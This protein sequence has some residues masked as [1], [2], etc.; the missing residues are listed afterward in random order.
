[1]L[2]IKIFNT[3][4]LAF[5]AILISIQGCVS[6]DP[7]RTSFDEVCSYDNINTCPYSVYTTIGENPSYKL[8]FI[9]FDDQGFL[10][11]RDAKNSVIEE[12]SKE[13]ENGK[14]LIITFIHGWNHNAKGEK[15]ED[16]DITKFRELLS[17]A[18]TNYP[19]HKVV[20]LYIGWRGRALKGFLNYATFWNRKSTAHEIGV[21]GITN[22][23]LELEQA[24]KGEELQYN[25]NTMITI[26]HSFGGAAL[27]SAVQPI[28]A[29]RY[30]SSRPFG[31]ENEVQGFGDL[32]VL[33]NP[34]FEAIRY[35]SLYELSQD[36]C[37]KYPSTQNPRLV[38]LS[39]LEDKAVRWTFPVG[40][41]L[42]AVTENHN[43]SSAKYCTKQG[44]STSS[45]SVVQWKA[46]TKAVGH[47]EAY[48]THLLRDPTK[49]HDFKRLNSREAKSAILMIDEARS[50]ETDVYFD[51]T[52]L[53]SKNR[54]MPYNP[55]LNIFT[56]D[57]IMTGHN[58][59]W[60]AQT[61]IFIEALI[62][63]TARSK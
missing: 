40:R 53:V 43:I 37:R 32:I 48:V 38:I 24:V 2:L 22:V 4:V 41:M 49:Y 63:F 21:N 52:V 16:S 27:F 1:M 36:R 7:Y 19:D 15:R 33:M 62:G 5:L 25:H 14:V 29:E 46:D 56:Q 10:H 20:G 12:I 8:G 13:S 35:Q 30:I 17:T 18:A 61:T 51:K 11:S 59:I 50:G 39:A 42:N 60:G 55:Y 28:L 3:R 23:L 34:A 45:Y 26:G 6:N 44:D 54:V 9:E 47:H 58:D 57:G 31:T